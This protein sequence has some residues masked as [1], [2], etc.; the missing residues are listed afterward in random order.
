MARGRAKKQTT[1]TPGHE[2]ATIKGM[3]VCIG[4]FELVEKA[5]GY[6]T[7][8]IPNLLYFCHLHFIIFVIFPLVLSVFIGSNQGQSVPISTRSRI[9]KTT[10]RH[11][12][13]YLKSD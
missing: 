9:I 10:N 13:A 1:P 2:F 7:A 5:T 4:S 6:D 3:L 12:W 11:V 8:T